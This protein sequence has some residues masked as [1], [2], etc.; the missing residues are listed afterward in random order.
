MNKKIFLIVLITFITGIMV[1]QSVASTSNIEGKVTDAKT[2]EPLLGANV[3]LIGTSMGAATDANGNYIIH[4][5]SPG[6]YTLSATYIGYKSEKINITVKEGSH[7]RQNFKLL[8]VSVE[9]KTV[10]VTAQASGQTQAIN[11]QLSSKNIINVV[12]AAKIQSLPDANAAESVGRLPGVSVLR[13][14]GEGY[15]V[16]VRGLAPQYNEITI[17]GMQMGS[18]D[19]NDR[20]TD[21]S[22]IS[23]SMLEGIQVAKTVTP[24]MDANVIGGVVNFEMRE[25]KV[26]VPGVPQIGLQLQGGYNNLSDAYNK[27][28]N[29][30]YIGSFEDR[31]LKNKLGIFGQIDIERRNLTS[32]ELGTSYTHYLNSTTQYLITS[33]N[34]YDIPRDRLRYN[35]ALDIDYEYTGGKIKFM[36]F[37]STG[38]TESN[39]RTESYVIGSN[40]IYNNISNSSDVIN[41]ISNTIDLK[42]NL[43]IFNI[44]FKIGHT[45]SETK[46]PDN[47]GVTFF[48]ESSAGLTPFTYLQNV[49]PQSVILSATRSP[50]NTF[51]QS[52]VTNSSFSR[53][54]AIMSSLDLKTDLA[55]SDAIS[56]E[57]KFGGMYRYAI[58]SYAFDQYDTPQLLNSGGAVGVIDNLINSYFNLPLNNSKISI[59]NFI[60]PNYD[61]G[62]F[63]NGDYKMYTPISLG[64]MTSLKNLLESNTQ[65]LAKADPEHYS[66][67]NYQSTIHNYSG[68]ENHSAFYLMGTF[69]IGPQIIFIP[70][71]RY[72]AFETSYK[73]IAG[74][75]SPESYFAYNHYDTTVTKTHNYWLPDFILRYKPFSWF[76][77]RLS[78]TNTLAYPSFSAFVP[79][80]DLSGTT[81]NWNNYNLVPAQ[82]KNYDAYFSFYNNTIGL[83]TIGGFLKNIKDMIYS[84]QFNLKGSNALKY[85]PSNL[86]GFN[87]QT[88]YQIYT[89][90]NNPFIN[91]VYGLEVDWQTHFWYL[92]GILSGLVLDVNYTHTKS[93]AQYPYVYSRS[94]NNGRSIQIID[95]SYTDRLI[96]QP[97]NIFNLSLGFDYKDFSIRVA[98]LYQANIFTNPNFWPQLKGFTA[99]YRRWDVAAKQKLPWYGI[100]L[101]VDLNNL[102]GANDV[103]IIQA[104]SPSAIEDYGF[105]ADMGLRWNF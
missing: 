10:V 76:D 41:S 31:F 28:N 11:Q 36:N 93:E 73:G 32:N 38:K 91:K 58:R 71:F 97:D 52:F 3:M 64:M 35:G 95:T 103:Q 18:S 56:V 9:G 57:L 55:I 82:S 99:A 23:S 17:N 65:Y 80:I 53:S 88:T 100:E 16:V 7:T 45:Y 48:Q 96:D 27:Y 60:D 37:L 83:L 101:Y 94:I 98:M 77:V 62:K 24:D 14:G 102:N 78:Y 86:S 50:S 39:Q 15:K 34:L 59:N 33:V 25:A 40:S 29:Y 87:S 79:K 44:D 42:Q 66:H 8:P 13:Q 49:S 63:L 2:G 75:T 5:V 19:P 104:G 92:P 67:N 20:S 69:K 105:T 6:S 74:V 12:S 70:G 26:K 61:Y 68:D 43:S 84:W 22:M 30:K 21:L 4:N 89:T 1:G 90:Q 51:L 72:Q 54:R 46:H 47:W 81:L 85:L